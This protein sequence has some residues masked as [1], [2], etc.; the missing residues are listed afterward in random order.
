MNRFLSIIP[1]R[2]LIILLRKIRSELISWTYQ[3]GVWEREIKN[4]WE[5]SFKE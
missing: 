1:F 5:Q 2:E 3:T 4:Y